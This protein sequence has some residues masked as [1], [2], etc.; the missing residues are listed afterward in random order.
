MDGT[1]Q[2]GDVDSDVPVYSELGESE[3]LA[4]FVAYSSQYLFWVTM[5]GI[6]LGFVLLR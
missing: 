6:G 5:A 1:E 4:R 2:C 3:S